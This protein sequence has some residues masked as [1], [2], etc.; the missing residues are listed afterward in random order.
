[1]KKQWYKKWWVW[2]LLGILTIGI[3]GGVVDGYIEDSYIEDLKDS[4]KQEEQLEN[5][6]NILQEETNENNNTDTSITDTSAENLKLAPV[7][8]MV[9][10]YDQDFLGGNTVLV[11]IKNL[12]NKNISWVE[13]TLCF[14]N[15]KNELLYDTLRGYDSMTWYDGP[16]APG[17]R[18]SINGGTFY[19][20]HYKKYS[21]EKIIIHYEDSTEELI[22]PQNIIL[23]ETI[24]VT[25]ETF[26]V[27]TSTT[28]ASY[29]LEGCDYYLNNNYDIEISL[30]EAW[31][32]GKVKCP[33]C[34]P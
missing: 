24:I 16:I 5:T 15:I 9:V 6:D 32:L 29:H 34:L 3:I 27:Y 12:T 13:Y 20:S 23:Y 18:I 2:V 10:S 7:E 31:E 19:N 21:V 22:T 26:M 1:M 28:A 33:H 25:P 17:E 4:Q 30:S 11:W 8:F 14:Y